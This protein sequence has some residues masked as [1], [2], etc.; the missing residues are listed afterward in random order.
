MGIFGGTA[1][2]EMRMRM[3]CWRIWPTVFD[4]FSDD[5]KFGKFNHVGVELGRK[6]VRLYDSNADDEKTPF[7]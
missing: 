6:G 4:A 2:A 3:I 7:L 5:T 1:Y